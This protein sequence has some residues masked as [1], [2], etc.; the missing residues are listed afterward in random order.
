MEIVLAVPALQ[1]V[2]EGLDIEFFQLFVD[3]NIDPIEHVN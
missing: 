2:P 1:E 3:I